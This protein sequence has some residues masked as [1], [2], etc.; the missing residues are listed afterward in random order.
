M[1]GGSIG[2]AWLAAAAGLRGLR[3]ASQSAIDLE[4]AFATGAL[5]L[6]CA[7]CA[8]MADRLDATGPRTPRS[9]LE[10]VAKATG[11]P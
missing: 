11:S 10:A 3:A 4:G 2:C 8:E 9:K 6:L 7:T 1:V 5:I